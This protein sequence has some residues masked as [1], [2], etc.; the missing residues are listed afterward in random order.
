MDSDFQEGFKACSICVVLRDGRA[1]HG[2]ENG[3][4]RGFWLALGELPGL[5]AQGQ[6]QPPLLGTEEVP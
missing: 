5:G 2:V 6:L 3:P 4:S 1:Q